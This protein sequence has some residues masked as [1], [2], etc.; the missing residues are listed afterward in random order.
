LDL[1]KETYFFGVFDGHGGL[2]LTHSLL[3]SLLE[4]DAILVVVKFATLSNLVSWYVN[5]NTLIKTTT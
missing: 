1:D 2:C 4:F 5:N 3:E